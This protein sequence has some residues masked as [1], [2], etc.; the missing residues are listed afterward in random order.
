TDFVVTD[1]DFTNINV[2]E[3]DPDKNISF[4]YQASSPKYAYILA[5]SGSTG[6]PKKVFLTE[7]NIKWLLSELYPLI[8]VNS[9]TRF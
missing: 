2:E 1:Y 6:V 8:H 7:E 4:N 3:F 5:T 9:E